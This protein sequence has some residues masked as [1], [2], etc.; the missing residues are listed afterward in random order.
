MRAIPKLL[1]GPDTIFQ[2]KSFCPAEMRGETNFEAAAKLA[3]SVPSLSS[4]SYSDNCAWGIEDEALV[5]VTPNPAATDPDIRRKARAVHREPQ[6]EGAEETADAII[7]T[8]IPIEDDDVVVVIRIC[9][10]QKALHAETEVAVEKVLRVD[11]P[12]PA[13]VEEGIGSLPLKT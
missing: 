7:I 10:K 9:V 6:G 1:F 8:V 13:M 11:C 4:P 3:H 2:L 12:T 5:I